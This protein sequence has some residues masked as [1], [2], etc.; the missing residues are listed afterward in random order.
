MARDKTLIKRQELL[1]FIREYRGQNNMSPTLE[2]MADK[3]YGDKR[4]AGNVLKLLVRPLIDEGFLYSARKGAASIQ[5][6]A[7]QP[8]EVYYKRENEGEKV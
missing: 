1:E 5:L 3:I 8:R 4:N 6:V 7:P 2:E